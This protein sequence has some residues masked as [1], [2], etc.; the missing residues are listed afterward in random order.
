MQS[1]PPHVRDK[2]EA[3]LD[4][5]V[6]SNLHGELMAHLDLTSALGSEKLD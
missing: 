3:Q 1:G 6:C 5:M 4:N 2:A